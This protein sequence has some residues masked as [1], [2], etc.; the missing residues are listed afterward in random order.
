MRTGSCG[1]VVQTPVAALSAL[2][3]FFSPD[4][5]VAAP[6]LATWKTEETG[7]AKRARSARVKDGRRG[8]GCRP[9]P[10]QRHPRES[11]G[12]HL[13]EGVRYPDE[14]V[15]RKLGRARATLDDKGPKS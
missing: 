7:K 6:A 1:T 11:G 10:L 9:A 4:L 15:H 2:I 8:L 12:N 3:C 14:Y 5:A 13:G